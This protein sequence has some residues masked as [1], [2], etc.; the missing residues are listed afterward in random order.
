MTSGNWI[1]ANVGGHPVEAWVPEVCSTPEAILFLHDLDAIAT[2]QHET[3]RAILESSSVPVICPLAGRTWWLSIPT[4]QFPENGPLGWVR[5]EVVPYIEQ[6]WQMKPPRIGII[7]IGMGGQGALNLSY[8]SARQF[9]VVAV[10]SA[11][12]DFHPYQASE[13][14][15]SEVFESVEAARQET[16]TLHLHPLNWPLSQR[17]A[18]H[19]ADRFWFDGC[20]RLAS[21]LDSSGIPFERELGS[22]TAFDRTLYESRQ[23][24]LSIEYVLANLASAARQL[25]VV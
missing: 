18:C 23:L 17:I 4:T 25:E 19:P 7:G 11:A 14:A 13:P 6:T 16:A 12:I 1:Q 15:L 2:S 22:L 10:I 24:R 5:E 9:P 21:K 3:W 20:E 8:R